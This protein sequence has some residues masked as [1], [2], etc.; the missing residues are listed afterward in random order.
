[1]KR[2]LTTFVL[3]L[4]FVAGNA[5]S[6][7]PKK[8]K[9]FID[10]SNTNCDETF[11]RTEINLVDFLLDRVASD[12]H[13]LITSQDIGSGGDQYQLIFFGQN[14][15]KSHRD[16]IRYS[17]DPNATDFEQREQMLR[18]LQLGLAPLVAKTSYANRLSIS[19]KS[20]LDDEFSVEPTTD[21][22][23]YWVYRVGGNGSINADQNYSS[24]NL[25][26]RIS[27]SRVIDKSKIRFRAF[28]GR[29]QDKYLI[30]DSLDNENYEIVNNEE[31]GFN[32]LTV[33]TIND[34]WSY[35]FE[36]DVSNNTFSN[37][38]INSFIL[39]Q[40][41]Y[42]FIPY[43]EVNTK[44]LAFRYGAGAQYNKYYDETI[45][46][47]TSE[48]LF[49]QEASITLGFNQKWGTIN[50]QVSWRNYFHDW[51]VNNLGI[52]TGSEVRITGGLSFY[53]YLFGGLV[54]D[55]VNIRNDQATETEVLTRRRQLASSFEFNTFFG[56][57]YRFGSKLNNFVNP[58]FEGPDW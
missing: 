11:I 20:E 10:C 54:H 28:A 40:I 56:L 30:I 13:V 4:L 6:L 17:T 9:V 3:L 18:Y 21:N 26:G 55:Q 1:M 24:L 52:S 15:Y 22:W 44:Y 23:N 29:R 33:L 2:T 51:S 50:A 27:A 41:E 8:L 39:P 45:Y 43:K 46:G 16:T 35:G 31:Y 14:E 38:E 34:R 47:K 57:N 32:S 36:F 58:R 7:P 12:V 19:L 53:V 37:Y 5:Q 48:Y 25:N 49:G 42:A